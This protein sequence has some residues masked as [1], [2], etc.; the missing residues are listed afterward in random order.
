MQL[1]QRILKCTNETQRTEVTPLRTPLYCRH[2]LQDG[3]A[4]DYVHDF[5]CAL[6]DL[7]H[8]AVSEVALDGVV[9]QVT[10]AAVQLQAAVDDIEA[11]QTGNKFMWRI[12]TA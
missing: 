4:H 10:V 2:S 1:K 3:T 9:L 8:A 7:V 5:I 11:L 12:R 6:K